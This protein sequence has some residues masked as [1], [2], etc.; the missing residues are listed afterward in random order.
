VDGKNFQVKTLPFRGRSKDCLV[1]VKV[2][3]VRRWVQIPDSP[4]YFFA[5]SMQFRHYSITKMSQILSGNSSSTMIWILCFNRTR[6]NSS[7]E[8]LLT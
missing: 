7:E 4:E 3:G 2:V 8:G 5:K 1:A 6:P